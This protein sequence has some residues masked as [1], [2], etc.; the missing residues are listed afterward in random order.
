[1]I[2]FLSLGFDSKHAERCCSP[3]VIGSLACSTEPDLA[4]LLDHL[5]GAPVAGDFFD[6]AGRVALR[7]EVGRDAS[8]K[9]VGCDVLS[10]V[11]LGGGW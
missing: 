11:D 5:G 3:A 1:M 2:A 10:Y 8:A 4:I 9:P 6:L 7:S